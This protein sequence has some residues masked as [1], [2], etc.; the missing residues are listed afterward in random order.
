M[1]KEE[2]NGDAMGMEIII[3]TIPT[4]SSK[5]VADIKGIRL[6]EKEG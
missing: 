6:W 5:A 2:K 1:E 4:P 3:L